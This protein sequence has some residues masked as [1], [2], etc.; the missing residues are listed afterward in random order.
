VSTIKYF[1]F[2]VIFVVSSFSFAFENKNA[3]GANYYYGFVETDFTQETENLNDLG[4]SHY[5]FYYD[6]FFSDYF[7]LGVSYSAGDSDNFEIFFVD[8][9]SDSHIEYDFITLNA[10]FYIPL[11]ERN[12]FYIGIKSIQ[13]DFDIIDDNQ[14]VSSDDGSDIGFTAG[15]GYKWSNGIGLDV[16]FYD[17]T[18]IGSD[19]TLETAGVGIN[20]NF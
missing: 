5:Q 20:Y 1:L 14:I 11:S 16:N 17:R 10:K 4:T 19:I 12:A 2:L 13:Y 3:V 8:Y 18:D 9:F 15:W 7:S 6:R